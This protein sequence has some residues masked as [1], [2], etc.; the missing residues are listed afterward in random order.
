MIDGVS[1]IGIEFFSDF[2]FKQSSKQEITNTINKMCGLPIGRDI[3]LSARFLDVLE[4]VKSKNNK[5]E[6]KTPHYNT[7][8]PAQQNEWWRQKYG[9]R[10]K[11]YEEFDEARIAGIIDPFND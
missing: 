8:K 7:H 9:E 3:L 5:Q 6:I 10:F 1:F 2:I 11:T 4:M